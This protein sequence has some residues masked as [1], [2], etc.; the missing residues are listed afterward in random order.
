MPELGDTFRCSVPPRHIW[1]IISDPAVH[2]RIIL[3]NIT[4]FTDSCVDDICILHPTDYRPFLTQASTIAYS[5][6]KVAHSAGIEHLVQANY[7]LPMPAV[8]QA[9]LRKIVDG[10]RNSD[11]IPNYL[12][13]ILPTFSA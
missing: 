5:R 6:H 2:E 12:K 3:V 1:I 7:F 8:P 11:G 4:T 9:T 10:A 13:L